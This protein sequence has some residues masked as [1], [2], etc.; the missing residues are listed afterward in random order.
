MIETNMQFSGIC[1]AL[2]ELSSKQELEEKPRNSIGFK[3]Q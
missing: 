2:I 1:Q 3:P